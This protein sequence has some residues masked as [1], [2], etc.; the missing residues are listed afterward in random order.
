[1]IYIIEIN[2]IVSASVI[3]FR[4]SKQVRGLAISST[5]EIN[6]PLNGKAMIENGGRAGSKTSSDRR[7]SYRARSIR[8]IGS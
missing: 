7:W 6:P 8:A 1:M 5:I 2:I 4:D 3:V